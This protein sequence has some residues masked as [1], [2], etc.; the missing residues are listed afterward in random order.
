M[1]H[2]VS[3]AAA[4]PSNVFSMKD[5]IVLVTGA[6]SGFGDHFCRVLAANGAHVVGVARRVERLDALAASTPGITA[7][8]CD[9]SDPDERRRLV[10]DVVARLGRVDVLINNAGIS[11]AP[12]AAEV[13]DIDRFR[14]VV[15]INLNAVYHLSS[16]CSLSMLEHGWGRIVNIASV[17]G[18]VGSSPNKQPAYVATKGAVI[19]LTRELA[20][21]WADRGIN[22]NAI[23]PAYFETEL[24]SSMFEGE[25]SGLRWIT[26]N[27]PMRRGGSL[28]ELDGPLLLLSS[29]ASSYM[30]GHCLSVDGGWLAR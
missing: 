29:D 19:S 14:A 2:D 15:E 5:R 8:R 3:P 16:L 22:V 25:D 28:H 23:A 12:S 4:T 24:T 6:S 30:T 11:D 13:D 1:S 9:V 10:D 20:L 18:W 26:R 17:H 21:Q 7:L 27:T